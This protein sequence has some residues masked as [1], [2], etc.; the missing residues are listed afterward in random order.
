MLQSHSQK[1]S[2]ELAFFEGSGFLGSRFGVPSFWCLGSCDPSLGC[3][4]SLFSFYWQ[5]IDDI[6]QIPNALVWDW[7]VSRFFM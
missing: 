2:Q 5:L 4:L 7:D 6:K 1:L 3:R